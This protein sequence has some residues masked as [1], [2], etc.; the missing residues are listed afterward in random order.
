MGTGQE[1]MGTKY[2]LNP[3]ITSGLGFILR[4][5]WWEASALNTAPPLLSDR[6]VTS[7]LVAL[8]NT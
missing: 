1:R 3:R 8:N 5:H 4:P 7:Q 2:K 6:V